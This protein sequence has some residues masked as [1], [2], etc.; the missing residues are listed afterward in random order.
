MKEKRFIS[1]QEF[2]AARRQHL[3]LIQNVA[4]VYATSLSPEELQAAGDMALWR[5]LQSH[6]PKYGSKFTTSL[7]RFIHWE[8]IRAIK[9]RRA[10][11]TTLVGDV[12]G[13]TDNQAIQM[14]LEDYLNLLDERDRRIVEARFLESCTFEEI[15]NREGY[16]KQGIKHIV[17]RSL[18]VMSEA[19]QSA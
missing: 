6:N 12:E 16:S 1:D 18:S 15:A 10:N 7:Y 2:E 9:E 8:C 19:A 3:Q 4:R 17:E 14:I 13:T 11:E 5:C